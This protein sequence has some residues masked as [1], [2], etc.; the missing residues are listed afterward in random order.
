MKRP[1][2]IDLQ[3]V[4]LGS[5]NMFVLQTAGRD[6]EAEATALFDAMNAVVVNM[7]G[8][9]VE[10]G[11]TAA[12]SRGFAR[13]MKLRAAGESRWEHVNGRARQYVEGG[14]FDT[15]AVKTPYAML[16]CGGYPCWA[17][18][19]HVLSIDLFNPQGELFAPTPDG[20]RWWGLYFHS[21]RFVMPS[22]LLASVLG[23]SASAVSAVCG[24]GGAWLKSCVFAYSFAEWSEERFLKPLSSSVL[25]SDLGFA[26]MVLD[27]ERGNAAEGR[28]RS[29][30]FEV[31][32]RGK[33]GMIPCLERIGPDGEFL[34]IRAGSV[35][36][37][38]DD[39]IARRVSA[40]LGR[41]YAAD[42]IRNYGSEG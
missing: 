31:R 13:L 2:E 23:A 11:V 21:S 7:G 42:A 24:F 6:L 29:P 1:R 12:E 26:Y 33:V 35:Y 41:V 16:S 32:G 36:P 30:E 28:L 14:E 9:L 10:S 15:L 17:V 27:A 39:D 22:P 3:R 4:R 8:W 19:G 18:Q 40:V 5:G 34:F 20:G 25:L 37:D 38:A